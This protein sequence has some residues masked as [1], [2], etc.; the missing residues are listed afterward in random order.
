MRSL[1]L[2]L[3][4]RPRAV[5]GCRFSMFFT[6]IV[7]IIIRLL[8]FLIIKFLSLRLLDWH[9]RRPLLNCAKDTDKIEIRV[10]KLLKLAELVVPQQLQ[11]ENSQ[12]FAEIDNPAEIP[13]L[14]IFE[15][16]EQKLELGQGLAV[17]A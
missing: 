1:L 6:S 8:R 5:I 16:V 14:Y 11:V 7:L 17:F 4:A 3:P 15:K 2:L 12:F 13:L 10:K 9:F